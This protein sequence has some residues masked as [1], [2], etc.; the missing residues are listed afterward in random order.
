MTRIYWFVFPAFLLLLIFQP[1][2]AA[3]PREAKRVLV[4][5]SED[6][7]NPGSEMIEQG[8][9]AGFRSNKLFDAQL[10]TEYLDVSRFWRRIRPAR[11]SG[12]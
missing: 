9:R 6:E 11:D 2:F 3:E 4:L 5:S 12:V 7:T 10:Y 8:I 1:L